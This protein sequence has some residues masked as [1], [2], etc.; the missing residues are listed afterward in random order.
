MTN[1][2]SV[3]IGDRA[4]ASKLSM[5][6]SWVRGQRHLRK[7]ELPHTLEIDPVMIGSSPRY[8]ISDVEA[9]IESLV[10]ANKNGGGN[11]A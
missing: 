10:P 1:I 8:L 4:V 7:R 9:F 2:E 3:L 6:Q 11:N 5:S